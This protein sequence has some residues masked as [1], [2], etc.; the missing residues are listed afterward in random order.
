MYDARLVTIMRILIVL[1]TIIIIV[2]VIVVIVMNVNLEQVLIVD[3][4]I[5]PTVWNHTAPVS[6]SKPLNNLRIKLNN[7]CIMELVTMTMHTCL[8]AWKLCLMF[9]SGCLVAQVAGVKYSSIAGVYLVV[10]VAGVK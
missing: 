4:L 1:I 10:Q 8:A 2:I 5:E 3:L 6:C 9:S 7:L